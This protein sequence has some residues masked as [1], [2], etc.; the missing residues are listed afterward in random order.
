MSSC[1]ICGWPREAHKDTFVLNATLSIAVV[2]GLK[3]V[4]TDHVFVPE[5]VAERVP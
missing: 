4:I 2:C 3:A 1:K 5:P